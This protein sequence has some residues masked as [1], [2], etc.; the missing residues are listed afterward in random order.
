MDGEHRLYTIG[1][2]QKT[3]E[4]F[5]TLLEENSVE[6]VVDVRASNSS[7]LAAFTKRSDLPFFLRRIAGIEYQH[8]EF[9]AP[10]PE[11]R[12]TLKDPEQGWTEYERRFTRLLHER[13]VLSRIDRDLIL[14]RTCCLLCTEPTAENCHRRLVAEHLAAHWPHLEICHL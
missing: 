14:N 9:L 6:V 2:T 10:T 5:F 3:A 1:Y 11:I 8:L 12:D 7:Q 4:Q 13:D